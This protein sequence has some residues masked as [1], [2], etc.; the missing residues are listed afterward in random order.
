MTKYNIN[1][2]C[3]KLLEADFDWVL[4][5]SPKTKTTGT[6]KST[7]EIENL[8]TIVIGYDY[9]VK[10]EYDIYNSIYIKMIKAKIRL[11]IDVSVV[12]SFNDKLDNNAIITSLLDNDDFYD[13]FMIESKQNENV[14]GVLFRMTNT[15]LTNED[16]EKHLTHAVVHCS[17][18]SRFFF[19]KELKPVNISSIKKIMKS[20]GF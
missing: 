10:E 1:Q 11:P 12:Y 19:L 15:V 2:Y 20:I 3:K 9:T 7:I 6:V 14:F 16:K 18:D 8:G 17:D 13:K 5:L 4:D